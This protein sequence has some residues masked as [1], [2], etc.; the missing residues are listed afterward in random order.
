MPDPNLT[1]LVVIL[2]RSGSMEHLKSDMEAGYNQFVKDQQSGPG[3]CRVTLV[4]FDSQAIETMY[5]SRLAKDVPL[6]TLVPRGGPPLYDAL[7]QTIDQTGARFATLPDEKR[8][9]KVI[10]LIIT[11]GQENSSRTFRLAQIKQRIQHQ[12]DVYGWAFSY[13]GTNVDAFAEGGAL[14]IMRAATCNYTADSAVAMFGAASASTLS[15]RGMAG[16]ASASYVYTTD[17]RKA[18]NPTTTTTTKGLPS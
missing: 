12:T 9:G 1:E 16:P 4:Q 2:D 14:G 7:G 17:Q 15:S 8:P 11:D 3:D 10:V 6:M 5:E 13:L 18:M